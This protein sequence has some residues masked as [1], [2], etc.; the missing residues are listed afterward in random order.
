MGTADGTV[1]VMPG[2][3]VLIDGEAGPGHISVFDSGLLRGDGCFEAMRSYQ[4]RLFAF[5]E[6]YQRLQASAAALGI[7]VPDRARL[8][9][10]SQEVAADG[11]DCIVRVVLTR[12]G[13][14]PGR[15]TPPRCVVI[16]HAVPAPSPGL[17]LASI[18][19]PWHPAGRPWELAGV[20]TISYAPNQAATRRAQAAGYDDAMLLSDEGL[21]LEGPTFSIAWVL[22][23][24][25]ET[26]ELGL[27]ILDSIT[28]RFLVG[29]CAERDIALSE[30]R[31][32]V[33]RL[34]GAT[35]VLA[36]STV[37]EVSAVRR[38]DG[39][40]YPEGPVVITLRK[41]YRDTVQPSAPQLTTG[42]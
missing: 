16:S 10:W 18:P 12:G 21:A 33:S 22:A 37:K 20:K 13:Q 40:T 25:I 41:A 35:E 2:D 29:I 4:G 5:S 36:F 28:R 9:S 30:G 14:I 1:R 17:A 24:K 7:S 38:L 19:A 8:Q 31:Y 32:H 39:W 23:G 3:L 11:G 15:E 42:R 27:G 34:G 6:H 26:P